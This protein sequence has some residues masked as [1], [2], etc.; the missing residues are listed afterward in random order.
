MISEKNTSLQAKVPLFGSFGFYKKVLALALPVMLQMLI[1]TL[2]SL[3]DN[4]MVAGLR[5]V[6][7][8]GINVANQLNMV[9]FVLVNSFCL[10][11]GIFIS[12]YYGAKDSEGMKNAYRFKMILCLFLGIVYFV[13]SQVF[14]VPLMRFM[15]KGNKDEAAILVECVRY[16]RIVGFTWIP[17]AISSVISSALRETE[18]VKIPLYFS[19]VATAINT[20]FNWLLIYGNLGF[21][22]MEVAGAAIAT[23]I[24]RGAELLA[25]LIYC[26]LKKPDF[27]AKWRTLFKISISFFGKIFKKS[28]LLVIAEMSWILT[29]T[30]MSKIY[31]G[32]SGSDLVSGFSAAWS[33]ANLFMLIINGL[34]TSTSVI[35]GSTLGKGELDEARAQAKWLKSGSF[36]LSVFVAVIQCSS[37]F[38]IPLVFGQLSEASHTVTREMIF[39]I[40]AYLPIWTVLNI[41]LAIARAGGDTL[42]GAWVDV[43]VNSV[44][45]FPGIILLAKFTTWDPVKM[46]A[47]IKLT[48][49]VKFAIATWQLKKERWVKNLTII[50]PEKTL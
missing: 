28:S 9:Y 46:F 49:V 32:R 47:V 23:V 12:Q 35:L 41:Q 10:A 26:K 13:L 30:V 19:V 24:A 18:Q 6:K 21:P 38:L 44:L 3:I 7:M 40:A 48:D 27:Y 11:G 31:N 15:V 20:I 16:T 42:L 8:A 14:P 5:D 39:I 4:F 22:R 1:Q 34:T 43:S 25:Y 45:F 37:I 17:I 50:E 36:V 2:I 33:I 29:E